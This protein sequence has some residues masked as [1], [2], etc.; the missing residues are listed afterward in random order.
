MKKVLSYVA[1]HYR[2][3]K[4][5]LRRTKPDKRRYQVLLAIDDSKS[6]AENG[7]ATF[8]LEA[9]TLL[10]RALALVEVGELGVVSFGGPGQVRPLHPLGDPFTDA[11][12][13]GILGRMQFDKDNSIQDRP[14][15]ELMTALMHMLDIAQ[16][17]H[18]T[19][20]ARALT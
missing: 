13:P 4:I 7:C 10:C 1:S 14:V 6:M 2:K 12:G 20:K 5:W 3:D 8:A 17:K 16:H 11:N 18:Q 9:L 19:G 15:V